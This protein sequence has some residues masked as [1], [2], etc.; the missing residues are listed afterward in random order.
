MYG[1]EVI[2]I[3]S[4]RPQILDAQVTSFDGETTMAKC[5]GNA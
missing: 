4:D 5:N 2:C 1:P 3:E